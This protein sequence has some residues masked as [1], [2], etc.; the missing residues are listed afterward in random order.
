MG[1]LWDNDWSLPAHFS[2]Q[3]D[4]MTTLPN[5]QTFETAYSG[6]APWDIGKPQPIFVAI[7]DK[8]VGSV[9]DAGCGTGENALFFAQRGHKVTGIDYLRE[10]IDRAKQKA[11]ERGIP[12]TFLV[13]DATRLDSLPEQFDTV[14]DCG[15]FHVFSD[16]DRKRYVAGLATVTKPGGRVFLAC[17]S[18]EEPGEQGPR[19]IS[20]ADLRTAF[21]DGWVMESIEP[22]RFG[23]RTDM[24]ELGFSPGGPKAWLATIGK[25]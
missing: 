23:V 6:K 1:R 10:P 9:L 4:H 12:A 7:A 2:C 22:I 8:V 3:D 18:D 20:Q 17:F 21:A 19:R 5:R 14:L 11:T 15:L 13:L 16:E 25:V 24:P